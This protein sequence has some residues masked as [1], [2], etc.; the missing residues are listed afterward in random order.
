[1]HIAVAGNIGA[2]KTTLISLLSKKCNWEAHFE[3][4]DNNPYLNDFYQDMKRWSF[5]LQIFFLHSRFQKVIEILNSE[6]TVVQDRT[7]YEDANIFAPNLHSMGL[8]TTR[9]YNNYKNLFNLMTGLIKPPDLLIY[10]RANVDTLVNRIQKRGREYE[11][12]ISIDYLTR[13]NE[14]YEA[15]VAGYKDKI[16]IVDVND[17]NFEDRP[18]D[19]N[20]IIEQIQM[21]L[22]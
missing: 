11:A 16:L 5:N 7:I 20:M 17:K 2:G 19:L 10:L 22:K 4:V 13:L 9:D 14:R 18:N 8:M 6:K 1:M 12:S 3:D 15:W 21:N